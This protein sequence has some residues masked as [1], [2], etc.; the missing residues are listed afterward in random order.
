MTPSTLSSLIT[1][2]W[3]AC[4]YISFPDGLLHS[5]LPKSFAQIV[6][7][8]SNLTELPDDLGTLWAD[9][10]LDNFSVQ[11]SSLRR[12][13]TTFRDL[14]VSKLSIITTEVTEIADDALANKALHVLQLSGNPITR[15]PSTVGD[16][17]ELVEVMA[18]HTLLQSLSPQLSEWWNAGSRTRGRPI[19]MSLF[20]SPVCDDAVLNADFPCRADQSNAEGTY[21]WDLIEV[22]RA[23]DL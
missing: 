5:N 1:F 9:H 18:E 12:L 10:P 8:K 13:P 20:G 19:T 2:H 3:F 6:I 7:T 23:L 22:Q 17:S 14:Q 16:T 15:W 21:R 11:L 4:P